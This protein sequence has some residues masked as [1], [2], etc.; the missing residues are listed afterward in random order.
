MV[1][2]QGKPVAVLSKV[3]GVRSSWF[4]ISS[5]TDAIGK[6]KTGLLW[7]SGKICGWAE[8]NFQIDFQVS[9]VFAR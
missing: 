8:A 3:L 4:K 7:D 6:Y 9:P 1:G 2:T 5:L